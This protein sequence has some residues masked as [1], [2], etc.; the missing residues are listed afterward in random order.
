MENEKYTRLLQI[1]SEEEL[2]TIQGKRI[3][4]FGLGGVGGHA[5]EALVRSGFKRFTIV[6]NDVVE[7]SNLNRQLLATTKTIGVPKVKAAKERMLEIEPSCHINAIFARVSPENIAE[8]NLELYD[9]IVDAIDSFEDK[10]ALITYAL[11]HKLP[12]ISAMGAGNRIDPT[13]VMI[14]KIEKTEGCPLAKKV[15]YR[16]RQE[17]LKGLMVVTSKELPLPNFGNRPGSSA[18]VPSAF[19][20]AIASYIFRNVI[21]K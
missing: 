5:L 16:L 9:F 19:G 14:T 4:V 8:F 13:R 1:I 10:M 21:S 7:T 17:K 6:D 3:I 18:F 2:T 15:R 20:L 11:K 12:I